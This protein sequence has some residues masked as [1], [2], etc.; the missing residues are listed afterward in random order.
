MVLIRW[1]LEDS[2]RDRRC[3]FFVDNEAARLAAI[4]GSSESASMKSLVRAFLAHELTHPIFAWIERVASAS[5]PADPPSRGKPFEA[6]KMLGIDS[7]EPLSAPRELIK[8]LFDS[9]VC[10]RGKA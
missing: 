8:Y 4:K 2:M 1:L 9:L 10:S 3:V 7:W 6:C 5:N